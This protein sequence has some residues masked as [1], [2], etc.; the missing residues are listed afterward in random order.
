MEARGILPSP[1]QGHTAVTH[2]D[3]MYIFGGYDSNGFPCHDLYEFNF[4]TNTWKLLLTKGITP[5]DIYYHASIVYQGSIYVFGGY[6]T[7]S[8]ALLEYR[9]GS[10]TWSIV[11][12]KGIAPSPRWG[13]KMVVFNNVLYVFGGRDAVANTPVC[14]HMHEF[15]FGIS[16]SIL[17]LAWII[18]HC[19]GFIFSDPRMEEI[20]L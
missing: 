3:G 9:F 15:H 8:S 19:L 2:G 18:S 5:P 6:R 16:M 14:L 12:T 7:Q 13:H 11:N 17:N 4:T 10:G 20:K 1:R